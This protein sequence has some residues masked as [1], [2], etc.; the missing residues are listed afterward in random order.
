[1]MWAQQTYTLVFNLNT[2]SSFFTW[3]HTKNQR[4]NKC[5]KKNILQSLK[6]NIEK[7]ITTCLTF[8]IYLLFSDFYISEQ[9]HDSHMMYENYMWSITV[10]PAESAFSVKIKFRRNFLYLIFKSSVILLKQRTISRM[11]RWGS[12]WNF[13]AVIKYNLAS[14][15]YQAP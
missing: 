11:S 10:Q 4:A 5:E 15:N 13:Y 14:K 3:N 9:R 7:I 8:L 12:H 6:R 1:M 2:Y